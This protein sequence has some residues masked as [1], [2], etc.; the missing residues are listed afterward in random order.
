MTLNQIGALLALCAALLCTGIAGL[1]YYEA[2]ALWFKKLQP[3]TWIV[4]NTERA[5][6]RWVVLAFALA[7]L[8]IGHFLRF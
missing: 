5:H 8:L 4:R 3:I 1:L 2:V 7:A 6:P